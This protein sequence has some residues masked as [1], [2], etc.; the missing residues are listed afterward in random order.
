MKLGRRAVAHL[1]NR[2]VD[3]AAV[4]ETLD[5]LAGSVPHLT[6]SPWEVSKDSSNAAAGELGWSHYLRRR[7][8]HLHIQLGELTIASTVRSRT[9]LGYIDKAFLERLADEAARFFPATASILADPTAFGLQS[10]GSTLQGRFL[11]DGS[12]VET[13]L[14]FL[15]RLST[16]T[17]ENQRISYGILI[18]N[19]NGGASRPPVD[20]AMS[21]RLRRLSDGVR[22]AIELDHEGRV[23]GLRALPESRARPSDSALLPYWL[24]PLASAATDGTIGLALTRGGEIMALGDGR[25]LF[26]FRSGRWVSWR[27]ELLCEAARSIYRSRQA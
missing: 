7:V 22:T 12:G 14:R 5:R 17:Y 25:L 10:V 13:A 8:L 18:R 23:V 6:F 27:P 20:K 19:R 11:R 9:S 1:A 26:A 2:G 3:I 16:L 15:R 4:I 24:R 21:K